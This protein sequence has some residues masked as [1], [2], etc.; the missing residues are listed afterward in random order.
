VTG[1]SGR[2]GGFYWTF[3]KAD[4]AS[5]SSIDAQGQDDDPHR[6]PL[7]PERTALARV[8]GDGLSR[9]DGDD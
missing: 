9:D 5:V 4:P 8:V 7:A 1:F 6:T 3:R 2:C